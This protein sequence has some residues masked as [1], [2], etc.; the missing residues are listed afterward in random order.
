MRGNGKGK[1]KIIWNDSST[2]NVPSATFT[3]KA[4]HFIAW[5]ISFENQAPVGIEGA[6]SNRSV[7]AYVAGDMAAFYR[8]GFHSKHNTLFD[9]KGRH[10]YD[11][12]Y[13]TGSID[14][15][16]GRARSVFHN[17]EIF[18]VADKRTQIRG[19]IT[20]H[21]R[22]NEKENSGF[23]FLKGKVYGIGMVYLGRARAA[24]STVI[25]AKTY[26]SMTISPDGWTRWSYDGG[27]ENLKMGEYKTRGPGANPSNR[28]PWVWK[29]SE[30]EIAPYISIGFID[31]KEWLPVYQDEF[32]QDT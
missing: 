28:V 15:I 32:P 30:E 27:T 8:C 14:F 20:A 22:H 2:D 4:Q 26:L 19:S 13:I 11:A 7:A 31:G 10:Y 9:S 25:F 23:V 16:F 12:S 29:L 1:T 3:V 17:C 6:K 21:M 5:G 18:V 24:Y